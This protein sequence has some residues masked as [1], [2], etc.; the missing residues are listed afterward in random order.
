MNLGALVGKTTATLTEAGIATARLDTGVLVEHVTGFGRMAVLTQPGQSVDFAAAAVAGLARRRSRG[1]PLAYLTGSREFWSLAF[2]VTNETLIP[3]PDSELLVEAALA[4]RGQL[5]ERPRLL[6]LGTGS[7]CLLLA[8]LRELPGA[9]G[10]GID[11]SGEAAALARDNAIRLGLAERA[12]FVTANWTDCLDAN[13]CYHI[14]ISNPPYI[15]DREWSGLAPGVRA[16]EP[17]RALQ[18]GGDGLGAYRQIAPRVAGL[19]AP[20]GLAI[21]EIGASQASRVTKILK[22]QGLTVEKPLKDL[23]GH[24]RDQPAGEPK[25]PRLQGVC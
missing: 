25:D 11:I 22:A 5:P 7:G 6:D 12:G 1:E 21:F 4:R 23:A 9:T 14:V 3:R 2:Q 13:G 15:S 20:G 19:L 24:D 10:L 18:G 8:L 16:F 17:A